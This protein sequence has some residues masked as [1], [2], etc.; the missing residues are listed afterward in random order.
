MANTTANYITVL[1]RDYAAGVAIEHAYRPALKNYLESLLKD[2]IA[3]N[4]L[5]HY[6]KIIIALTETDRLMKTID[7]AWKP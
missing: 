2:I 5:R 7:E 1:Q 4:D 3:I 6:A